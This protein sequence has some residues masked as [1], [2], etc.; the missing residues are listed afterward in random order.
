ML[1]KILKYVVLV[2]KILLLIYG[3]VYG[4]TYAYTN[5]V[6]LSYKF[7]GTQVTFDLRPYCTGLYQGEMLVVPLQDMNKLP[8]KPTLGPIL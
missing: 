3:A 4:A 8:D 5:R 2:I 6:C 7:E 1:S